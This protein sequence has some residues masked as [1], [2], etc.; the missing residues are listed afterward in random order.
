V[1]CDEFGYFWTIDY[2]DCFIPPLLSGIEG[3][4]FKPMAITFAF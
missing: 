3:K 4:M 2:L 1:L